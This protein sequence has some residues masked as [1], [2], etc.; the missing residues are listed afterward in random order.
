MGACCR[1]SLMKI[2]FFG[3]HTVGVKTLQILL[4]QANIIGV[5]AH[6]LDPEDGVRY[7]S[8]YEFAKTNKIKVL[9]GKGNDQKIINFVYSLKPDLIWVTDY[10]YLLPKEIFSHSKYG[11][12]NIHPSLLPKYRGRASINW[13][14]INGEKKIGLTAH[15]IDEHV[16]NGDIIFQEKVEISEKEDIND[17]LNKLYPLYCDLTKKV[18]DLL[19]SDK[20]IRMPQDILKATYYPSRKPEDGKINWSDSAKNIFNLVRALTNPYPGAFSDCYMG[21]VYIWKSKVIKNSKY[22]YKP[23]GTIVEYSKNKMFMVKCEKDLLKI[24]DWSVS[25]IDAFEPSPGL[26]LGDN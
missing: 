13:A 21:R 2:I 20:V 25:P 24:T 7:K 12:I 23:T 4:D 6:P 14:I 10:R 26:Q 9:R 8:V 18:I 1:K 3:N 17:A 19:K 15:F 16:D 22:N 11:A 5:I